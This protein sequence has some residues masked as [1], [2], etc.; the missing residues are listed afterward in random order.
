MFNPSF[1][2]MKRIMF[3]SRIKRDNFITNKK[4]TTTLQAKMRNNI[5]THNA[6]RR[7]LHTFH[8]MPNGPDWVLMFITILSAYSV[9]K[10]I[11]KN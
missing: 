2:F 10:W 9:Q 4:I 8:Q 7:E 1:V 5:M 6:V 11:N 3:N